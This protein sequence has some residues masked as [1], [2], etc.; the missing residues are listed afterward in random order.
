MISVSVLDF[1]GVEKLYKDGMVV[2]YSDL[3]GN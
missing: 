1:T 3:S 2:D